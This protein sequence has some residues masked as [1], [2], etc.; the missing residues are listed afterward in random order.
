M[1]LAALSIIWSAAPPA[2]ET[3][4]IPD[5]QLLDA[6]KRLYREGVLTTG[7]AL[8]GIAMGEIALS[9][10]QAACMNCHRRSGM[11]ALEA[12]QR[13]LPVTGAALYQPGP[14][15]FWYMHEI[16]QPDIK[17]FRPAYTDITL[18][19][20][21]REGITPTGRTLQ[22]VMPRY[23]LS[24]IDLKA[25]IA[26]L[27]S[28]SDTSPAIDDDAIHWATVVTPDADPAE[29]RAMLEVMDAFF[30]ER[31]EETNSYL[32]NGHIPQNR[33]Y[34]PLRNWKLHVWELQGAPDTWNAQLQAH[35]QKRPVF[36]VLAGSG[37]G[38]WQPIHDFCE[39]REVACLFPN[40]NLPSVQE[41]D[42][43]SIYFS[44]GLTLEAEALAEFL[45][46][47]P[48]HQTARIVQ[49]YREGPQ[50]EVP[51]A[52][53]RQ[54]MNKTS[55]VELND[56]RI[57]LKEKISHAF[58]HTLIKNERP[59]FLM[60]WLGEQDLAGLELSGPLPRAVYLSGHQLKGRMPKSLNPS[61][62]KLYLVSPWGTQQF[63]DERFARM[64]DWMEAKGLAVTDELGQGN[65]LWL[66]WVAGDAVEQITQ[67]FSSDYLIERI[68]DMMGNL[69]NSSLYPRIS[70]GPGQ[71]FAVKGCYILGLG[72]DGQL[73]PIGNFIVPP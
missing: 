14:P 23:N 52:S 31:N 34:A 63:I 43:Y 4:V 45:R 30:K 28:I 49:V 64:R 46:A 13:A 65:V 48:A 70:L 7:Q 51:A 55:D 21:I 58:W 17:R 33:G 61:K 24:D 29:R 62:A 18:A 10:S 16:N 56:Y 19:K 54:V 57:T 22:P 44:R 38:P 20:A 3:P 66:L 73:N 1:A 6:G 15:A 9:G 37:G 36:A 68:E 11:G 50:G 67:H 2:G 71:R 41:G 35:F 27:K 5:A 60:L 59:D 42:F 69:S 72:T 40:T 53:F 47:D 25:L 26:Y 32:H 12:G 39:S 8:E